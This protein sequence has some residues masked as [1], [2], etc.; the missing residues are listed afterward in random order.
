M[1]SPRVSKLPIEMNKFPKRFRLKQNKI[2]KN[3]K[4]KQNKQKQSNT[5]TTATSQLDFFYTLSLKYK[6]YYRTAY[7]C[8]R[9]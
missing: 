8:V 5:I 7:H 6:N 3:K 9:Y 4:K 2:N 1:C